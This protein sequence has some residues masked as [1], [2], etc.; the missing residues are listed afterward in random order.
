VPLAVVLVLVIT[1]GAAQSSAASR[2]LVYPSKCINDAPSHSGQPIFR[3]LRSLGVRVWSGG[4]SWAA[5]APTRPATPTSPDDP[6]Y[7]WPKDLDRLLNQARANGIEPVL[8]VNGFPGW[9]NGGRDSSWAPLNP[10]DYAN[11]MAAAVR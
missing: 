8:L 7:R 5:I 4:I 2:S 3:E 10:Q 1:A 6:A 11:F 9:S